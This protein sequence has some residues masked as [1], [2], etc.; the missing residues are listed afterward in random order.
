MRRSCPNSFCGLV[1][2]NAHNAESWC[3]LFACERRLSVIVRR[4]S[5]ARTPR[6][7]GA[8]NRLSSQDSWE[9]I[10]LAEVHELLRAACDPEPRSHAKRSQRTHA[11]PPLRSIRRAR[12]R[13]RVRLRGRVF[14]ARRRGVLPLDGPAEEALPLGR[15]QVRGAA[16]RRSHGRPVAARAAQKVGPDLPPPLAQGPPQVRPQL[17]HGPRPRVI[18]P[19]TPSWPSLARGRGN[20]RRC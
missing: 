1:G 10:P 14:R 4:A 19:S 3:R 11:R 12:G 6:R 13:R 5:A 17:L 16:L 15:P 7:A 2:N 8:S 18:R 20:A 9:P